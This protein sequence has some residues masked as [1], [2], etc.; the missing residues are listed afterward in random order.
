MREILFRGKRVD[1][2]KWI[3]GDLL[4]SGAYPDRLWIT[5][6]KTFFDK[7]L[8]N[9]G[10]IEVDPATVGQYTGL[11]DMNGKKIFEGDIVRYAKEW[12]EDFDDEDC[13]IR[14]VKYGMDNYGRNHFVYGWYFEQN[15]IDYDDDYS[16]M[17]GIYDKK[18]PVCLSNCLVVCSIHDNPELLEVK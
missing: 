13:A 12:S 3:E 10:I 8:Q 9:I 17:P 14:V 1:D 7:R 4:S 5:E 11:Q 16:N 2:G 6:S 18:L 15:G